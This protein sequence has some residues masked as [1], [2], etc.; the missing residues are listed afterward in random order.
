MSGLH[1]WQVMTDHLPWHSA[2]LPLPEAPEAWHQLA[3]LGGWQ[4]VVADTVH[5]FTQD[6]MFS[7]HA[8]SAGLSA[9]WCSLPCAV[10][11]LCAAATGDGMAA[12]Q[13]AV[14]A[15]EADGLPL[16]RIVVALVATGEG[17][18]S[19]P[20]KA[21]ATMLQPKVASIVHVPHDERIRS[22]GLR[23]LTRLKT[24]TLAAG[25]QLAEAVLSSA[26]A[27]WG[28]TLPPAAVPA[29]YTEG[30]THRGLAEVADHAC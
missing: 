12:L 6:V 18:L 20:V 17:R 3:A 14:M 11:V 21:G 8:G 4:A 16:A 27:S 23:D 7:R 15:A 28:E 29:A 1:P 25:R 5:A 30:T 2:P 26:H 19:A 24:R 13:T 10:P 9:R 22:H